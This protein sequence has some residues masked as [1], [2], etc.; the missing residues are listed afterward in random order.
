[1]WF[2]FIDWVGGDTRLSSSTNFLNWNLKG[3]IN[4]IGFDKCGRQVF[5]PRFA[6]HFQMLLLSSQLEEEVR[7]IQK[8]QEN[9]PSDMLVV[10]QGGVKKKYWWLLNY[11]TWLV[12][13]LDRLASYTVSLFC[14]CCFF[15]SCV[16]F[17]D[18]SPICFDGNMF[19]FFSFLM[20]RWTFGSPLW[21]EPLDAWN[22]TLFELFSRQSPR[23]DSLIKRP[24]LPFSI[25]DGR[26]I[27]GASPDS[28]SLC[29]VWD[30]SGSLVWWKGWRRR[31]AWNKS[32]RCEF[33]KSLPSK[34][35]LQPWSRLMMLM[36][37]L[38]CPPALSLSPPSSSLIPPSLNI[39]PLFFLSNIL[40]GCDGRSSSG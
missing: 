8:I 28:P 39:S 22:K 3:G 1:M 31:S 30:Q 4:L 13:E 35:D 26:I 10:L 16:W 6:S 9:A 29:N 37:S 12:Q 25:S 21:S 7:W 23:R 19:V 15:I 34:S 40:D 18:E 36:K 27:T 17:W 20:D 38:W 24:N 32:A 33:Q 14:C 5:L 11:S 2:C